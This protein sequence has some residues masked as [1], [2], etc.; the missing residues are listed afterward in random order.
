MTV[1]SGL[2][3]AFMGWRAHSSPAMI[4]GRGLWGIISAFCVFISGITTYY[5]IQHAILKIIYGW[6]VSIPRDGQLPVEIL[7]FLI[8]YVTTLFYWCLAQMLAFITYPWYIQ[9]ITLIMIASGM[10]LVV[11]YAFHDMSKSAAADRLGAP[12]PFKLHPHHHHNYDH[13]VE[14]QR[15]VLA[16]IEHEPS[17]LRVEKLIREYHAYKMDEVKKLREDSLSTADPN[18]R[19]LTQAVV[20]MSEIL[21]LEREARANA[22][23][24]HVNVRQP[25]QVYATA[26]PQL[27]WYDTPSQPAPLNT[28]QHTNPQVRR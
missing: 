25:N 6:R 27:P 13:L 9:L 21:A 19:V 11:N 16:A 4:L 1:R 23:A 7:F 24:S 18:T 5:A 17:R 14:L 22:T 12:Q 8:E 28:Q 15:G 2:A 26:R 20:Q 10:F 3:D